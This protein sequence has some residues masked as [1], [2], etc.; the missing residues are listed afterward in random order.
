MNRCRKIDLP[1]IRSFPLGLASMNI[2]AKD[3]AIIAIRTAN[4]A[5]NFLTP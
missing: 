1:M 3:Q 2:H 5:S 4:K